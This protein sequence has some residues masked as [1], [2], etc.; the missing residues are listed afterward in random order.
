MNYR[1]IAVFFFVILFLNSCLP[2]VY[3]EGRESVLPDLA[4]PTDY[5]PIFITDIKDVN[6]HNITEPKL[7]ISSIDIKKSD[8]IRLNVHFFDQNKYFMTGATQAEWLKKWCKG[9]I[10][11]NGIEVPIEKMTIRESSIKDRKP[12]AL[13]LVM[14]HSGSMGEDRAYESQDAAIDL[15]K[16]MKSGDAMALIKYDNVV[17]LESPLTASPS[18]L[19]SNLKRNG[20]EGF[21]GMTA[22]ND[23]IMMAID[24]ISKAD[25]S[26]QRVVMVFTDGQE[27][28]SKSSVA[29]VVQKAKDKNVI[30]CAI[31]YGYGINK[32][33][34]E[35]F[36]KGT[37]GMYHH[38]YQ[39]NEFKLAFDDL[40]KRFE[41][42]YI[43][44]FEQP[45]Y[46]DH[47]VILTMC[48]PNNEIRDTISFNNLPDIG[49][50]NLLNVYFDTDKSTIKSESSKAIKKVAA[51]MKLYP[52][53]RIELRGHTDSNNRT[54]DPNHNLKLSQSRA[55]AV[56]Q[57]LVKEGIGDN[58]IIAVGFGESRPVADNDTPEGRAQNRRTEF[59]ILSK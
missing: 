58:R 56:K 10:I 36:S 3:R 17:S 47:Q 55:D 2:P 24:E 46:G 8:K 16:S 40:Y 26:M 29:E 42:F 43:V 37:G 23:A 4:P 31:D 50:I 27:N 22:V 13:A 30:I 7:V 59:I 9:T 44:E 52:G 34:M 14:D 28:A 12:I 45:D 53:M 39:K 15:I 48:L 11:T 41:Y 33:Y 49:F 35:Q 25:P 54:G 1:L 57:T 5:N 51:M 38:I 21:G 6:S 32:G 19:L 18:L 20:L